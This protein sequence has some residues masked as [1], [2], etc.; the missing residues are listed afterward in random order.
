MSDDATPRDIYRME[1]LLT[2]D[3]GLPRRPWFRHLIYAPGW[4]TGY[5]AVVFPGVRDA[6]DMGDTAQLSSQ[7][8]LLVGA[9]ERV[10]DALEA[11]TD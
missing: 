3:A 9:C 8:T 5:A 1:R 2:S 10:A 4:R 6:L 7:L 11:A